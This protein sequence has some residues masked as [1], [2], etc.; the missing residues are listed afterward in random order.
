MA[1]KAT[2]TINAK[3]AQLIIERDD[4]TRQLEQRISEGRK[5]LGIPVTRIAG[6]DYAG[7]PFGG[8][9][10]T[11]PEYNKEEYDLFYNSYRKWTD[12]NSELLK[13]AFDIPNNEYYKSYEDAGQTIILM[14]DEDMVELYRNKISS[15][16]TNLES[17]IEKAALIPCKTLKGTASQPIS[18]SDIDMRKVFIVHGHG[19]AL[20]IDTARTVEHLG[21]TA[22]ILHEREDYGRTIIEKFE[23][24][25]SSIGFAIILLT[26][27]DVAVSKK[28]LEKEKKEKGY[29]AKYN[30]RA[31]QNVVFEMG[32]FIGKL[33]RAHVFLL[34]ENGVEKPGDLD[35]IIYTEVDT[36]GMWKIKL[37]KRLKSVGYEINANTII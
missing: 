24:E 8:Y 17:L 29:S 20:K 4:F 35:G 37:A 22:I 30:S 36:E 18:A 9:K 26:A 21:L 2:E 13:Q 31:R 27:D 5:L 6:T 11:R 23:Q 7:Y 19:E 16:I 15:K 25:A 32:Y 14:G 3:K 28:D 12:Y 34:L 33:N 10:S 1:K